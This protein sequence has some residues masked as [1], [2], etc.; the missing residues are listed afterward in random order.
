VVK[1]NVVILFTNNPVPH[2]VLDDVDAFALKL[3]D[4]AERNKILGFYVVEHEVHKAP[5]E[6]GPLKEGA[7]LDTQMHLGRPVILTRAAPAGPLKK[8]EIEAAEIERAMTRASRALTARPS[9]ARLQKTSEYHRREVVG[10]FKSSLRSSLTPRLRN[11]T[12]G[13]RFHDMGR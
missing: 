12:D 3:S 1:N 2:R 13:I 5:A 6:T 8:I 11:T 4:Q 10:L 7:F 9:K